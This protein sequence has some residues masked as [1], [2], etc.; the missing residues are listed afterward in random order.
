MANR[1]SDV[2]KH[3]HKLVTAAGGTTRKWVSPNYVGV[4]DRI[5]IY[6]GHVRFVEVKTQIGKLSSMQEREI[7]R[8][9][10]HGAV[11]DVVFGKKGAELYVEKLIAEIE[12]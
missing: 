2:E 1:E 4:P 10:E 8:L 5:V 9:R 11:V 12:S 6:K 7:T 3:L